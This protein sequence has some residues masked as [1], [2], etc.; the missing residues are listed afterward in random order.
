VNIL[1]ELAQGEYKTI[2]EFNMDCHDLRYKQLPAFR[3]AVDAKLSRSKALL[4]TQPT[5]TGR[6]VQHS[7]AARSVNGKIQV[8]YGTNYDLPEERQMPTGDKVTVAAGGVLQYKTGTNGAA[9]NRG[10]K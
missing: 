8:T 7:A 1:E 6:K 9:R 5:S 2:A 4:A 3:A 10:S